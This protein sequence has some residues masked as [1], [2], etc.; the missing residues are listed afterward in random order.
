MLPYLMIR[1]AQI[2]G[3]NDPSCLE[4]KKLSTSVTEI[5]S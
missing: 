5:V 2:V 1:N 4:H 3:V